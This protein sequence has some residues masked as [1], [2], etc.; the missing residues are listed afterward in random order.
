[1]IVQ[2]QNA[3]FDWIDRIDD[4]HI[5]APTYALMG[6]QIGTDRLSEMVRVGSLPAIESAWAMG[7]TIE[8]QALVEALGLDEV[9][10]WHKTMVQLM[11]SEGG[12]LQ[13]YEMLA[14]HLDSAPP[15][16]DE[17]FRDPTAILV[18]AS[19]RGDWERL[20]RNAIRVAQNRDVLVQTDRAVSVRLVQAALIELLR[21]RPDLVRPM[22]WECLE[23]NELLAAVEKANSPN[24][25]A[26][27]QQLEPRVR[28]LMDEYPKLD[29]QWVAALTSTGTEWS[30]DML[31][32]ESENRWTG[33]HVG[34]ARLGDDRALEL[35]AAMSWRE[36]QQ[37][38]VMLGRFDVVTG[39][40][41]GS[42]SFRPYSIPIGSKGRYGLPAASDWPPGRLDRVIDALLSELAVADPRRRLDLI[43]TLRPEPEF[44]PD[45]LLIRLLDDEYGPVRLSGLLYLLEHPRAGYEGFVVKMA[46]D[47]PFP[48]CRRLAAEILRFNPDPLVL[49]EGV[50]FF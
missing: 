50:E 2:H 49:G 45:R 12:E 38:A 44:W 6:S 48:W 41:P 8:H 28:K 5:L 14:V 31:V 39:R 19:R 34:L 16:P 43:S 35:S 13:V 7:S 3:S 46:D 33:A 47:D 24:A 29:R 15:F 23:I 40:E 30:R 17:A 18:E 22:L 36:R 20:A 9:S 11:L 1:M 32:A 37:I 26:F 42:R 21:N 4:P 25:E 10:G 27:L